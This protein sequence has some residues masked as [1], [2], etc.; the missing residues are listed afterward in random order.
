MSDQ[1][2]PRAVTEAVAVPDLE[3]KPGSRLKRLLLPILARLPMAV[4]RP[5][6]WLWSLR[7]LGWTGGYRRWIERYDTMSAEDLTVL[8][9]A[10]AALPARPLLSIVIPFNDPDPKFILEAIQSVLAQAYPY[11]ELIVVH[12]D[13]DAFAE[14]TSRDARVRVVAPADG[15]GI[16]DS[17]GGTF[18][19]FLDP[20][21]TLAPYALFLCAHHIA[22]SPDCGLIYS[23][24][25]RIDARG[26]RS[27]PYFKSDWNPDLSLCQDMIS[28]FGLFRA[29]LVRAAG[30]LR[31]A[32][33]AAR[34]YD[35]AVRV[36]ELCAPGQIHHVPQVLYHMRT[37]DRDRDNATAGTRVVEDHLARCGIAADVV[38]TRRPHYR[39]IHRHLT[40]EPLV[41]VIIPTKD[42][43]A[44]LEVCVRGLTSQTNYANLEILIVDNNSKAQETQIYLDRAAAGDRR[45]RVL[46]YPHVFN[47][48]KINNFAAAQA[49]GEV[50]LL[51]NNDIEVIEPNWLR[52]MVANAMRPEV[53][54]VGARLLYPNG[55]VQHGGVIV[56]M[57]GIAGHFN[58]R[59]RRGDPGYFGRAMSQQ[60]LSA[61]TAACLAMRRDVF[62]QVGG[63]ETEH[64]RVA[65]N[66]VDLCLRVR[67]A[68]YLV[69]W[70]PLAELYHHESVSRGSDFTA[71]RY[72]EFRAEAAYLTERWPATIARDPYNNPNLSVAAHVPTLA[73]P[74]RE[75]IRP[76]IHALPRGD[77]IGGTGGGLTEPA[78][79]HKHLP[80][81]RTDGAFSG[82]PP[83]SNVPASLPSPET[84]SL[85]GNVGAPH[86][87]SGPGQTGC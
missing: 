42:Q 46:R 12:A 83:R 33:G 85:T 25:D 59:L 52:H 51:L 40:R 11:W 74:P 73:N 60:N 78:P 69:V 71:D 62:E 61:V 44:L 13:G 68:G 9:A 58:L 48:S 64:L 86:E 29:D 76:F 31:P 45:V 87:N 79:P 50:L 82:Q 70:T 23:D 17:A 8:R 3:P 81:V 77:A 5:I 15:A 47:Y 27:G 32:F 39:H 1:P 57:G 72:D 22:L 19:G 49:T 36:A 21:D 28:R 18:I 26:R 84:L 43:A 80:R 35:L 56:G 38:P 20:N 53:G 4:Q 63:L 37:G 34:F 30:G 10:V 67:E 41:S 75:P 2:T 16:A 14:Y 65:Y 7:D 6:L 66:D 24:E 55:R 54:A